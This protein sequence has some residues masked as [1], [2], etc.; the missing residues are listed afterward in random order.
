MVIFK[1]WLPM[2]ETFYFYGIDSG[3][4]GE[5]L[6]VK[7]NLFKIIT[8]IFLNQT[9]KPTIKKVFHINE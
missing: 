5:V 8:N 1:T 7:I 9:P 2:D 4:G 3:K 6:P